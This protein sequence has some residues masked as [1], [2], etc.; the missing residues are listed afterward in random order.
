M[1]RAAIKKGQGISPWPLCAF[2]LPF[3]GLW[4]RAQIDLPWR[5]RGAGYGADASADD[6]AA[7][8]SDRATDYANGG[9]GGSAG[10]GAAFNTLR[11][12]A[13]ASRQD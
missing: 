4:G 11:L 6:G 9:A 1:Q 7:G 3:V 5:R 10:R 8:D 2:G 12:S 13:A